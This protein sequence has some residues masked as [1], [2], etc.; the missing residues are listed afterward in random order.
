MSDL[1]K[2][3]AILESDPTDTQAFVNLCNIAE[4]EQDFEYLAELLL[5]RSQVTKDESEIA[6][7]CYRAGETYLDRLGDV[8][9]GVESLL[10]GFDNDP[11]H[12]GIGDRLDAI[13]REAEDWDASLQIVESRIAAIT[14]SDVR[15]TKVVIRSDLH[16]QAGEILQHAMGD[17]ETALGHYRKAIELDK[18]NLM[19]IYG[20]REI[21]YAAGKFKN[22]AKLCELE[23]RVEKDA[24]R[25]IALYR[26]LAHILVENLAD[27][28]QAVVALKRALKLNQEDGEVKLDL[29]RTIAATKLDEENRKDHR[30]A[31]DYLLKVAKTAAPGEG[32]PLARLALMALPDNDKAIEFIEAKAREEGALEEL[33]D[34]YQQVID[35]LDSLEAKAPMIRR[36]VKVYVEE[37]GVPEEG[38]AWMTRLE[39]LGREE[40]AKYMERLSKGV[41]VRASQMPPP[42][43]AP[44]QPELAT[45]FDQPDEGAFAAMVARSGEDE[46]DEAPAFGETPFADEEPEPAVS[47]VAPPSAAAAPAMPPSAPP[48]G[49]SE[50]QFAD[51]LLKDAERARRAGDDATAEERMIQV[52]EYIPHEQKAT[53][54]LER[55]FR[56]RGDWASLRDLLLRSAGSPH[57]PA[58]VQTVRLREAARLSEEQLA[59]IDGA[60]Q[61]WRTIQ[62][63]DPK[64]RDAA[65][66]LKRLLA[67]SERWE[68]LIEVVSQE[69][70]TTKSRAKRI[71]AYR[72]LAEIYRIRM[73][74]GAAAAVAYK[75]VLDLSPDDEEAIEALDE[76]YLREQQYE[77][78]VPL[79][80][81]RAEMSR[82]REQKRGFLL[83]AAITLRERLDRP[84]DAY[85]Q[86][87]EILNFSPG[88]QEVLELMESIDEEAEQWNRLVEVLSMRARATEDAEEKAGYLRKRALTA[89]HRMAN[90]KAAIKAW[91][92]VLQVLPGDLEALDTLA[93][94]H[95]ERG[96]WDELVEILR[97]RAETIEEPTDRAEVHRRIAHVL[98]DELDRADEAMESWRMVLE[99]SGEDVESLGALSRYYERIEDWSE[100]VEV[101][102]RQAP[103]AEDYTERADIM[104]RR[105]SIL[106]EQLGERDQAIAGFRQVLAEVDPA[107]IPSLIAL[108]DALVEDGNYQEAIEFLEQQIAH[109]AEREELKELLR[110]LGDWSRAQVEDLER[111][112]DA[113]EKAV[114][115]DPTDDD[116]LDLL[117]EVYTG[118]GEWD[119]LLKLIYGRSQREEDEPKKLA[120][121]LRGAGICEE[122]LEDKAKA[123]SW[124]RQAFDSVGHLDETL[125]A[126]EEAAQR[127]ELWHE[128]IDV[129]GVLTRTAEEVAAQASWWLKIAG[130]FEEKLDD[131]AQALEAVLRAFGLTPDDKELLDRVD[132]LAVAGKNW[133][134]LS[135]VYGVLAKRQESKEDKINLLVRYATVL[136]EQGEQ[137]SMA[138]D[139]AL[140]A[141]EVDPQREDLLEMVERIGEAAE[142][143]D[144][145]VRL[146][147]AISKLAEEPERKAELKM[148]GA[149]VLRDR[150]EDADG[151]L[152]TGLEVLA[153][154]PFSEEL[155]GKVWT[156]VR[157]LEDALLTSE[158][159]IYWGKL[160]EVYRQLVHEHRHE[161]EKQVD[162]LMFVAM[163]YADELNDDT[164]AFE[165]L[166]EAQ[167]INPR[168]EETIDKLEAMAEQHDFWE[169]LADHYADIL[170]ETFETD[171]AV[172]YHR[173][174]ARILADKLDRPDEA[175]EH[176]QYLLQ[177]DSKDEAAYTQLLE[178]FERTEKW[179]EYVDLLE[180]QIDS[181]ADEDRKRQL[182]HQIAEVW[183]KRIGNKFE[184]K[185]WYEQIITLWPD[186]EKAQAAIEQLKGKKDEAD[187]DDDL[188]ELISIPPPPPDD[189]E[190]E[191]ESESEEA[192]DESEQSEES[193]EEADESD[194]EAEESDEEADESDVPELDSDAGEPEQE[195]FLDFDEEEVAAEEGEAAEAAG[196]HAT[197]EEEGEAGFLDFEEEGEVEVGESAAEPYEA[198][199]AGEVGEGIDEEELAAP[200]PPEDAE[201]ISFM[202]SAEET[203]AAAQPELAPDL[204]EIDAGGLIEE[205]EEMNADD[206]VVDEES[207][208]PEELDD[209]VLEELDDDDLEEK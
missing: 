170:D 96:S 52:L 74:D 73:N 160:I 9:R 133:Q 15:G 44:S 58:A 161:R 24:D 66:A 77:E 95:E 83:R 84:E 195:G 121:L 158:K 164:S 176:Y 115:I 186:D 45:P 94:I 12:A 97:Q 113:Y 37:L 116:L 123:W 33:V 112:M 21:Y 202:P 157:E 62:E 143:W 206:L 2:Y 46:E 1:E 172:M 59:D 171:V 30:W 98:E 122:K 120:M 20:A 22:A 42:A 71:E 89:A 43:A 168:D 127:L 184:A 151:A 10:R 26:E 193:D 196:E 200:L 201:H 23:A 14:E 203:D 111:A 49:M 175:V 38:L 152:T 13:Y 163:I 60:I 81:K 41:S 191:G 126:V 107:H 65:D 128:L 80:G 4:K 100:F 35:K 199:E 3:Q 114:Q 57:L 197:E 90:L 154:D 182:F 137:A 18:T 174:R 55:R 178:H 51:Q 188:K 64:V 181:T 91:H 104:Y 192:S 198:G 124:L 208:T 139:V 50:E 125:P 110:T 32:L 40:D 153:L 47:A 136:H 76:L 183:E 7:L 27:P 16:Q 169:S 159:G 101:L 106:A 69:A 68:E 102:S 155:R 177:L 86:A 53:T 135:T 19:A 141:F 190:A 144:D 31:A 6:D 67:D 147:N 36:L 78:L 54:Y 103:L 138:F 61:A 63:N 88:D 205:E 130:V 8:T 99:V 180:R 207:V 28:D 117:D 108:R 25:R 140:K 85:V 34:A 148:R 149:L 56:A 87:Q 179:N 131:A 118:L 29:A 204:E 79:L 39:P 11:T 5:Y 119:K 165:C 134:R 132:R 194:E 209:D 142:R 70:E 162:L 75:N 48:D 187:E 109:T 189:F 129:Y 146:Y 167:Q 150:I 93:E 185:D 17:T 145:M 105:S 166:K 92:E 156:L 173:R 72:R 82:D